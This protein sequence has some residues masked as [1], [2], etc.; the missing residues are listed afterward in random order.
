MNCEEAA[1]LISAR[2][3]GEITAPDGDQLAAHLQECALCRATTEAFTAQDTDLRRAYTGCDRTAQQVGDRAAAIVQKSRP[4]GGFM[5]ARSRFWWTVGA[6]AMVSGVAFILAQSFQGNRPKQPD[7]A[8]PGVVQTAPEHLLP[9]SAL[10]TARTR[11][12]VAAT[13]VAVGEQV[14]TE[15]GQR[16]RLALPDGSILFVNEK[17]TVKLTAD[18]R[19]KLDRGDI[20]IEVAP[21]PQAGAEGTFTVET[22]KRSVSALGTKFAVQADDAGTGVVVTQG[23]V[24]VSGVERVVAGGQ[25]LK[26][27]SSDVVAA[28]RSSHV[29]DWTRDLMAAAESP[30]VPK[31]QHCG[32]SL[33]AIDPYGQEAN[34]SLRKYRVDVHIEDGFA[35]TTIDQTYFNHHAWRLEGTFHFPLPADAS[36]S[37]LAMY[38]ANGNESQLMEGGMAERDYARN[39]FE[40]I[41]WSQRDP[42]LLEWV[43]GSTFKM[44]VFPLEGRQEKRIVLSYTQKLDSLYGYSNYRFPSGHSLQT[45]GDWSFHARIKGAAQAPWSCTSHEMKSHT[46]GNDLVLDTAA[47]NIK[48][49]KDVCLRL[50]DGNMAVG[51][52]SIRFSRATHEGANYLMLRYRPVLLAKGEKQRRDWVFLFEASGDRDPITARAQIDVIKTLLENAEHQDTFTILTANTRVKQLMAEPRPATQDNIK[53]AL[54]LLERVHLIGALDLGDA[55]AKV[56]PVLK[57]AQNPVLVHV[58][59]GVG[60]I[61]ERREDVLAKSLPD[62]VPY[63]GVGVGKRWG[64]NF[65]KNASERSGGAFTQ[66]NPDE[67]IGW[68]AFELSALL[69]TPRLLNVKVVDNDEKVK[70]LT[71]TTTI[72][73]GEELCAIARVEAGQPLPTGLSIAGTLGGQPF[74]DGVIVQNAADNAGYLP[75]TWAKLE[76]DRLMAEDGT[77]HKAK[78]VELSKNMYVMTPF[79]SL[80]VL[81]NEAMYKQFNVDRGRKDH[82]AMYDCPPKI[83]TVYEPQGAQGQVWWNQRWGNQPTPSQQKPSADQVMQSILVRLPAKFADGPNPYL[84][85]QTVFTALQFLDVAYAVPVEGFET[86]SSKGEGKGQGL[87]GHSGGDNALFFRNAP[88]GG[89]RTGLA[90]DP[91]GERAAARAPMGDFDRLE[92]RRN[93][94]DEGLQLRSRQLRRG[95]LQDRLSDWGEFDRQQLSQMQTAGDL[96]NVVREKQAGE[97]QNKR[98][99]L[100][101][102]VPAEVIISRL[103]TGWSRGSMLYQ[104]PGFGG[105]D[106]WFYDLLAHAPAMNTSHADILGVIDSE[107]KPDAAAA[108]GQVDDA[109]AK[110]IEKVR[111]A[112]WQ[113][114][115]VADG[116]TMVVNGAGHFRSERTL[117]EGLR[118]IAVSDGKTL[119]HLYPDLAVGARREVTRF[120]RDETCNT[121]PWLLP[122]IEDLARGND[123]KLLDAQTLEIAPRKA[124][125][126]KSYRVSRLLITGDRL[127]ERRWI[128]MPSGK[129]LGQ[130]VYG[131]D[132]S[133]KYLVDGKVQSERKLKVEA[134]EP[135]DLKLDTNNIA[136]IPMPWRTQNHVWQA[137]GLKDWNVNNWKPEAAD[138]MFAACL[139]QNPWQSAQIY[140]HR[141]LNKDAR[142]LGYWVLLTACGQNLGNDL[143]GNNQEPLAKY[144]AVVSDPNQRVNAPAGDLG[145]AKDGYMQRLSAFRD[146]YLHWNSGKAVEGDEAAKVRQRDTAL[147]Y[148]QQNSKSV[149]GWAVLMLVRDKLTDHAP[150]QA[151]LAAAIKPFEQVPALSQAARYEQ[152]RILVAAGKRAEARSIFEKLYT[153]LRHD[154]L[155]PAIDSSF[156]T[157]LGTDGLAQLMRRTAG[158]LAGKGQRMSIIALAW[159]C[160]QLDEPKLAD[161]LL[162]QALANVPEAERL[163]VNVAGVEF[164]WQTAQQDAADELLQK[165]LADEKLNVNPALWRLASQLAGQRKLLKRQVEYFDKALEMEFKNL[166]T[167]VNIQRVRNDYGRLLASYQQVAVAMSYLETQPPADFVAKVVRAADRWRS[168][169]SDPTAA[170][171]AAARI[172]KYLGAKDLAWDYMTTP[173]ALRPNESEP[174]LVLARTLRQDGEVDLSDKAF[175]LAFEAESTNPQILLE[176]AQMLQQAGRVADAQRRYRQIA[177]GNW[178]PRFQWIKQQAQWQQG[179]R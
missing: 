142:A 170:C 125:K 139:W 102:F 25:Q 137:H 131:T 141:F 82:W 30:L 69:N 104:R 109:A 107:A 105:D 10:V 11:P 47:K 61:G 40:Q 151:I 27:G 114:V 24:K 113:K 33:I 149:Y 83:A 126:T 32:G 160:R 74:A 12:E 62:D 97:A 165:L 177:E 120:Q 161:E 121:I 103:M 118:E 95:D 66:I 35:R 37:R 117:G 46:E 136:V 71:Y 86:G 57:T 112:G 38:V 80:L 55:I 169:D 44:R 134:T 72:A 70:F 87:G 148:V 2:L 110:L 41:V 39:V 21:K 119:A 51:G 157:A 158:E 54:E 93:A 152:A 52:G 34:L 73:Q 143:R 85:G 150:S 84:N 88:T 156:K 175:A 6:A 100:D 116:R 89:P 115:T 144:L 31:S 60:T 173:T 167:L 92:R 53:S 166:P 124:D 135:A 22:P 176:Q 96:L 18:R 94:F 164:L 76:I 19:L 13:P 172:L 28:P 155:L 108:P 145:G 67:P 78:I 127:T 26:P 81:E 58:G 140:R 65:M 153:E 64:R 111:S 3:D 91:M 146:L 162:A 15:A 138:A 17:T 5:F 154:G 132:G 45:V 98:K 7:P 50:A 122:T 14:K 56:K 90:L 128:E 23:K 159:Q 63:V 133:V 178:Q 168:L 130:E 8:G 106:R 9:S 171:H 101:G 75:R 1:E 79:T 129:Q 36:L 99:A 147:A 42:A 43:D 59:S 174:H 163:A 20:F 179:M 77:K 48:P 29:L 68:R 123:I 49:E 4:H 16:K